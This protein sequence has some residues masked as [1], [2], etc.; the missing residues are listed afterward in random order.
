RIS[1]SNAILCLTVAALIVIIV[2]D[3]FLRDDSITIHTVDETLT[4]NITRKRIDESPKWED[5]QYPPPVD[6]VKAIKLTHEIVKNLNSASTK[7]GHWELVTLGL[8]PLDSNNGEWCY[9]A[10]FNG[11]RLDAHSG[12][13]CQ[14]RA[15]ILMNGSI[16]IPN[17]D[18]DEEFVLA[19]QQ[20]YRGPT[21]TE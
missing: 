2:S 5:E 19:M 20:K 3:R 10:S 14:F 11:F 12:P 7:I 16:V 9:I 6:T 1:L 21:H 8:V 17:N 13:P 4:W 18:Y 15:L